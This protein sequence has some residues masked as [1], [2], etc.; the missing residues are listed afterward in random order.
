[1]LAEYKNM[2]KEF[3]DNI[4]NW[5][6][7]DKNDLFRDYCKY[8]DEDDPR[9]DY[10]LAAVVYKFWYMLTTNYHNQL[11]K[12]ASEE[13]AYNWLIDSVMYVAKHR[14]W[15]NPENSLYQDPKGPEK[16]MSVKINSVKAN[17]FVALTH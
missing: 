4:P 15:D 1:M 14:P 10:Y 16:A 8:S 13:D 11:L 2:Y 12:I 3:A 17:Y 6:K 5:K 7:I 9:K